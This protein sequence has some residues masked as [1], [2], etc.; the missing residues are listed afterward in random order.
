MQF[1]FKII[2]DLPPKKDGAQSMWG[3][4]TEARRLE[5]LRKAAQQVF[6]GSAPL[7]RHVRL[8]ITIYVGTVNDRVVGDLDNFITGVCDGLMAADPRA[9]M[10]A[11]WFKPELEHIH[12]T[13]PIAIVGDSQVEFIEAKKV[14]GDS[15]QPWYEIILEGE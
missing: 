12:P 9:K 1:Q 15:P 4:P 6:Q 3:K 2:G 11:R 10:D 13:K 7:Q 8:S 14:V 5:E